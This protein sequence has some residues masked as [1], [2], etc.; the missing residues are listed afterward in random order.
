MRKAFGLTVMLGFLVLSIGPRPSSALTP[1]Q[2]ECL[3]DC[4]GTYHGCSLGC[5]GSPD[6]ACQSQCDAN[7]SACRQTCL[8]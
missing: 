6:P 3:R 4:V 8:S 5:A 2:Q 7:Y 1:E